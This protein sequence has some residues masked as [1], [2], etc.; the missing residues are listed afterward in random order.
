VSDATY[1]VS[2]DA[3]AVQLAMAMYEAA[4]ITVE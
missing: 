1:A 3:V 2:G 4:I